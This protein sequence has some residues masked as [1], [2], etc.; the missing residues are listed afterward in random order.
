MRPLLF[1]GG[2]TVFFVAV[3]LII[4]MGYGNKKAMIRVESEPESGVW[5]DG[6]YVGST[7][8]EHE[9]DASD[10]TLK[11]VPKDNSSGYLPYETRLSLTPHTKTIV[12]R[13]FNVNPEL[14]SN[15]ILSFKKTVTNEPFLTIVT[16][17]TS[18]QIFI[19]NA[20]VG[21]S[22][23]KVRQSIAAHEVL[24]IKEGYR[25]VNIQLKG[26]ATYETIASLDLPRE[27][28][29]AE[30]S[31]SKPT[32]FV[33]I[34]D[35]PTGFLNVREN[36]TLLAKDIA[37]VSPGREYPLKGYTEKKDWLEI[38]LNA[39]QSGWIKTQFATVSA[40]VTS[41]P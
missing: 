21:T 29:K 8:V 23:L 16:N 11:V 17:P 34:L 15:Q 41:T 30:L 25:A 20:Y 22:P 28:V 39:S 2:I 32:Q 26:V 10:A 38:K 4:I 13:F 31:V 37:R 5:V 14:S 1:F 18:A 9:V 40:E 12:R 36:P 7:P 35:T 27:D 6:T 24:V 3:I 19:D 33:T